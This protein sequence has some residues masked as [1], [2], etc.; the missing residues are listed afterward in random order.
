MIG[1][2]PTR[3]YLKHYFN[4][5]EQ[6]FHIENFYLV[7]VLQIPDGSIAAK[8]VHHHTKTLLECI[9]WLPT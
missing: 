3:K 2:S 5:D 4:E 7:G 1:K 6:Y 9:V 8:P